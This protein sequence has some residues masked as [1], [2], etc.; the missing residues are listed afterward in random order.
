MVVLFN[1]PI[2]ALTACKTYLYVPPIPYPSLLSV[3]ASVL[4][5]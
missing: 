1:H 2:S 5:T 4:I 3:Y